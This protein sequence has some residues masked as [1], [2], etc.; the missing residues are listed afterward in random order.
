MTAV[1]LVS[2]LLLIDAG[3]LERRRWWVQSGARPRL[4]DRAHPGRQR[5]VWLGSLGL[6][7]V[8]RSG[9]HGRFGLAV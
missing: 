9:E 7:I 5:R 2:A 4:D 3:V 1:A 8:V 6:L